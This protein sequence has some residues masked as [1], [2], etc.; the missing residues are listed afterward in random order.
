M[1]GL[2][3]VLGSPAQMGFHVSNGFGNTLK[4]PTVGR[5]RAFLDEVDITDEEHGAAWLSTDDG[6]SLEWNGDGR[7]VF[8]DGALHEG[9]V[10]HL[11]RVSREQALSLWVALARGDLVTV[12]GQPWAPG[13]G[14]VRTPEREARL[15]EALA[16]MDHDFYD[17]LGA[18]RAGT[19]CRRDGCTRGAVAHS[20]L[21][22]PH[23]FESLKSRPSPF[24][25]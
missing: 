13:N 22:R 1:P 16:K 7:L 18:E 25:D 20:V 10:R 9:R 11:S 19:P 3:A 12:E 2:A 8:D 23:H 14:F 6:V 21:C 15:R 24:D 4:A 5:M 17:S